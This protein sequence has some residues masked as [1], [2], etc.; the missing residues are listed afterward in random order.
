MM[1]QVSNVV[2]DRNDIQPRS[3][4]TKIWKKLKVYYKDTEYIQYDFIGKVGVDNYG[5]IKYARS[6]ESDVKLGKC[7]SYK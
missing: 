3:V 7:K 4:T 6:Y 5:K 1:K 2:E